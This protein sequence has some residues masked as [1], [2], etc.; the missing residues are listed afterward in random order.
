MTPEILDQPELRVAAV[1]HRGPYREIGQAFGRLGEIAGAAGLF[2]PNAKMIGVYYDDPDTTPTSELR[3]AAGVTVSPSANV[4]QELAEVRIPAGRVARVT[5]IGS[6]E[7]L[8]A[9]WS[10]FS[11]EWLAENGM[12]MRDGVSYEVY[13]NTPMDTPQEKLRTELYI[14]IEPVDDNDLNRGDSYESWLGDARD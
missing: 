12:R 13:L 2:G 7:G 10:Q 4:P 5:H 9:A 8:P 11:G 3:S 1:K 6:Y 14:P